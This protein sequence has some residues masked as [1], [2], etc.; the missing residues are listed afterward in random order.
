MMT[1]RNHSIAALGA[2]VATFATVSAAA[3][4]H[5][6]TVTAAVRY[7]DLDLTLPADA[8]KLRHRIRV[9]ANQVCGP[10]NP[11]F[12]AKIADCRRAA[13]VRAEASIP[14]RPGTLLAQR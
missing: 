12:R 13:I 2:V 7:G 9:A 8:A 1:I 5:A 4:A 14:A 3:P 11:M 10:L 6:E